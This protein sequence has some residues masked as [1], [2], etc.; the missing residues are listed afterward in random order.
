[1]E[2]AGTLG[3]NLASSILHKFERKKPKIFT[4]VETIVLIL[5]EPFV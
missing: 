5:I 1:M 4:H 3:K 2:I